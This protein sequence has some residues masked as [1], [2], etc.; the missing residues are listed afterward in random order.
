MEGKFWINRRKKKRRTH[1]YT[2]SFN[3]TI[4]RLKKQEIADLKPEVS[5]GGY[6]QF[7]EEF[8]KAFQYETEFMKS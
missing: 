6:T 1:T 7:S 2:K 8:S 4:L 5:Q 3:P